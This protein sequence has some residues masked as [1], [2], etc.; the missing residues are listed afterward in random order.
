M[1]NTSIKNLLQQAISSGDRKNDL[2]MVKSDAD[3]IRTALLG[4]ISFLGRELDESG[5]QSKAGR[6]YG[7]GD[8]SDL[9]RFLSSSVEL[10]Q[11]MDS[12]IDGCDDSAQ[13]SD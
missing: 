1:S 10:I 12:V 11:M 5:A 2:L 4:G 6:S 3:G 13:R 9:G 8:L 7:P